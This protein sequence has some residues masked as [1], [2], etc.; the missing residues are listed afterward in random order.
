VITTN[1]YH[2]QNLPKGTYDVKV[3][4]PQIPG[5]EYNGQATINKTSQMEMTAVFK[6]WTK[7][8][9]AKFELK[10]RVGDILEFSFLGYETQKRKVEGKNK[11][12][13]RMV[14]IAK[15]FM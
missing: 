8:N 12:I 7:C 9:T 4:S 14:S 15:A 10:A 11:T 2:I 3:T 13:N 5:C 6:G 1:D